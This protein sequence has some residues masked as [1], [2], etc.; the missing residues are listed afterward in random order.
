MNGDENQIRP[1]QSSRAARVPPEAARPVNPT[2]KRGKL[3]EASAW[4]RRFPRL[5]VGLV[6][7]RARLW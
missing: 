5:R 6:W 7:P 2:R 3:A 4:Q 1:N